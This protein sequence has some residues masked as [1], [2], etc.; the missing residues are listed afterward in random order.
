[1]SQQKS[2]KVSITNYQ[3]LARLKRL[4]LVSRLSVNEF[5]AYVGLQLCNKGNVVGVERAIKIIHQA[6]LHL[7]IETNSAIP[8]SNILQ[9]MI[10]LVIYKRKLL[11]HYFEHKEY[12]VW[13]DEITAPIFD[14]LEQLSKIYLI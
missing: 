10:Y 3:I 5:I 4:P 13:E 9:A 2:K 7:K 8:T 1:M 11:N 6:K 14:I 12:P